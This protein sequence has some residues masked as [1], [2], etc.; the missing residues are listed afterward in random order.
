MRNKYLY[1]VFILITGLT[2]IFGYHLKDLKFNYVFESFFPT[3][4][5]DLEYYQK[6]EEI[7][8]NDNDYLLV[9]LSH[10][11]SIFDS[12]F[13]NKVNE[14][15]VKLEQNDKIE[16]VSSIT[17][18]YQP[19]I[20]KAGVFKIPILHIKDPSRLNTDS[21]RIF[22]N[23][24]LK[25]AL[26][27]DKA[28][29][30]IIL[31][32]HQAITEKDEADQLVTSTEDL[33]DELDLYDYHLAG[34][35]YAQGIFINTI[36]KELSI[37][38]SASVILVILFLTITF[39]SW[40]AV[41]IPLL[42][43]F[44]STIWILGIM[45]MTDKPL[46]ILM[47]LLPTIMFVV[48]MSDVVHIIT[49]YIE[50]LRLGN[51]KIQA[52]KITVKEVG[53]ATFLTS[54]T[55]GI[56]FITL[57][58]AS[59]QPIKEFGVYTAT[60]VFIAYII[61]FTLLPA[62]LILVPKPKISTLGYVKERWIS[63]LSKGFRVVLRKKKQIV[64]INV[65]LIMVSLIGISQIKINT[66]LIEDLPTDDPLKQD[67]TFFDKNF[68]GSRPFELTATVLAPGKNVLSPE[69][70]NEIDNVEKYLKEEFYAGNIVSPS[71]LVKATNQAINGG[72]SQEYRLPNNTKNWEKVQPFLKRLRTNESYTRL[73]GKD[74]K[75]GRISMR[76]GDIGSDISL[77]RTELL[78]QFILHNTDTSLVNFTVT[79]TSNLIDKNNEYLAENMFYGL[80]IAFLAVALIAGILFKSF[81]MVLITL[82]PNIVPLFLVAGIMGFFGITLKLSTSIIF[83]IAFGI[84]VDD[85]I[86]FTSKLK[87]ELAK[88][89][90]ILYALK[91]T[92]LSTGKAIIITS[93]ILSA[94]FLILVLSSF[95]GTFYTGLLI[96]LTLIF[97]LVIDLT[98]LPALI[99]LTY[100]NKN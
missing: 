99:I 77:K 28:T 15:T 45:G 74:E 50:Q 26:I 5:P 85:T 7:F 90:S 55:T 67:F 1:L 100:I 43:V 37:F 72:V 16:K 61:S 76:V 79:G 49:K 4:D 27:N 56:G 39:R 44:L 48:A 83:T 80:S 97:A 22:Q 13:L 81:K 34:K 58:T 89:K 53:I 21:V 52:I 91:R 54:L 87:I 17:N 51:T 95:G 8:G 82:I 6:F 33:I 40:W 62:C 11:P 12:S 35:I 59:I 92:Y 31:I 14:L 93:I 46:D 86:H 18:F 88:G 41:I 47:V 9:G 70:I 19:V 69:I 32:Q 63:W 57:L 66:Y 65:V 96:S 29:A 3:D 10:H 98:L 78:K 94:G 68:G 75:I 30:T 25:E 60:G 42:V 24:D 38:L 2:C 71:T 73:I 64:L 84:A 20:S 36:Q 23:T